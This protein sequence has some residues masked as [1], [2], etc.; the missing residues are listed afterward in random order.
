[1]ADRRGHSGRSFTVLT[2]GGRIRWRRA[3]GRQALSSAASGERLCWGQLPAPFRTERRPRC[4]RPERIGGSSSGLSAR[5]WRLLPGQ[6]Q[7]W[8]PPG[9]CRPGM[10]HGASVAA[11]LPCRARTGV[12]PHFVAALRTTVG[13]PKPGITLAPWR[14]PLRGPPLAGRP[15]PGVERRI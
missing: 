1:M 11:G 2:G 9:P 12:V 5:P 8:R 6:R 7:S 3:A 4:L 10:V 14:F 13:P 15:A